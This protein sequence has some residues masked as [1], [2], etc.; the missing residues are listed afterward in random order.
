MPN[1]PI[2]GS[3]KKAPEE[4]MAILQCPQCKH[5]YFETVQM[6]QVI[7]KLISK[8]GQQEMRPIPVL[9]CAQCGFIVNGKG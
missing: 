3:T 1:I 5:I 4:K 6:V 8:S 9:R 2:L 7:S